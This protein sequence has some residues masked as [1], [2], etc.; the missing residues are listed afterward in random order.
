[1]I[2]ALRSECSN[3]QQKKYNEAITTQRLINID[4]IIVTNFTD[5][6]LKVLQLR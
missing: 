4:N 1:M 2:Q 3:K 5:E 6:R